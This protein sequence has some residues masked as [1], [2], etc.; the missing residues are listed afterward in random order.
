MIIK[1]NIKKA[2]TDKK[3]CYKYFAYSYIVLSILLFYL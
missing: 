3:N 1:M 2:I